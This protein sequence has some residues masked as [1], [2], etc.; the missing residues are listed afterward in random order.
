MTFNRL[1]PF[2]AGTFA[3]VLTLNTGSALAQNPIP[4][5]APTPVPAATVQDPLL[6]DA[7]QLFDDGK[8]PEALAMFRKAM[9]GN[10]KLVDAHLGVARVL[11]LT[12]EHADARKHFTTAI[13]LAT[14]DA[15]FQ[16]LG[17]MA[18]SYAFESKAADAAKYYE[19]VF[20]ERMA[21]ANP[22]AAAGA[23]NALARIYLESGDPANAEKWYRAGFDAS[24]QIKDLKP[25][26]TDLWQM[27]WLH[28]QSR[29]AAK[30]GN[31]ADA[32]RH[33]AEMKALLD[34]G[35]NDAELVQY[36]YL[37]GYIALEA[38]EYD[39][40]IAALEKGN[41][42]DPFILGLLGRAH[43]KKGDTAKAKEYFDKVMAAPAHTINVAFARQ[44]ARQ[45]GK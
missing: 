33:A 38:G 14:G 4:A 37:L 39:A 26:Q 40:A 3:A 7:Q 41:L 24:K 21:A 13:D 45:A 20:K 10:P 22:N 9:A 6:K 42:T 1:I 30:R 18:V 43:A 32:K 16:A 2:A 34:K 36:Q 11:D 25:A 5:P 8:L 44:W 28:A 27:R 31:H 17:S 19:P 23:A 29:I 35:G 12:G 15:R